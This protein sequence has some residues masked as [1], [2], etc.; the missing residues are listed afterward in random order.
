M[1]YVQGGTAKRAGHSQSRCW[2]RRHFRRSHSKPYFILN[3]FPQPLTGASFQNLCPQPPI[4][5]E[6]PPPYNTVV[7]RADSGSYVSRLSAAFEASYGQQHVRPRSNSNAY[8]HVTVLVSIPS[9]MTN[10]SIR[11]SGLTGV[12]N[13]LT[14]SEASV[15]DSECSSTY[16]DSEDE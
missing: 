11:H 14:D 13:D 6:A 1:Q 10:D 9:D 3:P 15:T 7:A 8:I 5:T 12:L 2:P 4:D 16:S